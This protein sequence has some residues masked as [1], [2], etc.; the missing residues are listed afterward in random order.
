M[1]VLRALFASDGDLA[2]SLRP[3]LLCTLAIGSTRRPRRIVESG[4]QFVQIL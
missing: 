3:Y 1:M 2:V 4:S